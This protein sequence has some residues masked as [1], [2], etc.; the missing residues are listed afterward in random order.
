MRRPY[1][2]IAF[3][4]FT[5][6]SSVFDSNAVVGTRRKLG[7]LAPMIALLVS[8]VLRAP[9]LNGFQGP[10]T[11]SVAPLP[12]PVTANFKPADAVLVTASRDG[13][14]PSTITR[15]PGPVFLVIY[16]KTGVAA[17]RF[18]VDAN[19]LATASTAQHVA[20]SDAGHGRRRVTKVLNLSVGTFFLWEASN[21]AASLKIV[22]TGN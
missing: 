3:F 4:T 7:L 14:Y 8:A 10:S 5:H 1:S 6:G 11:V 21:S 9:S 19:V 18:V 13:F 22:V 16:D 12:S 17:P 15:P 2:R 20:E